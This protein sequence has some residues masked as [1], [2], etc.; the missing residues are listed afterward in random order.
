[1]KPVTQQQ[2]MAEQVKKLV[3]SATP[4]L[5]L[6]RKVGNQ[7]TRRRLEEE[8]KAI[9]IRN[10]KIQVLILKKNCLKKLF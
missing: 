1:M 4:E 8:N 5:L 3:E 10:L 6:H 2:V 9:V 7:V